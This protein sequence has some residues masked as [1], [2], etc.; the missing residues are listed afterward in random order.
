[1]KIPVA[2]L[3]RDWRWPLSWH[4]GP[5]E[6]PPYHLMILWHYH[7]LLTPQGVA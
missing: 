3:A 6:S 2:F 5:G 1:V 4:V 7:C